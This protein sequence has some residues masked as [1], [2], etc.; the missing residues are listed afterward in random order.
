MEQGAE[1]T[2][3]ELDVTTLIARNRALIG[4]ARRFPL[5]CGFLKPLLLADELKAALADVLDPKV[6]DDIFLLRYALSYKTLEGAKKHIVAGIDYR[7]EHSYLELEKQGKMHPAAER[8]RFEL[9]KGTGEEKL[10]L[11]TQAVHVREL[12]RRQEGRWADSGHPSRSHQH[13]GTV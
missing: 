8:I 13:I 7:K 2:D 1:H 5:F 12:S 6:H 4:T 3:A 10:T 11:A 9:R